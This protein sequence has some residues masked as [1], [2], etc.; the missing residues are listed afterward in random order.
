MLLLGWWRRPLHAGRYVLFTLLPAGAMVLALAVIAA[1]CFGLGPTLGG[2]VVGM[3]VGEAALLAAAAAFLPGLRRQGT[4]QLA[5]AETRLS[6][7]AGVGLGLGYL[8]AGGLRVAIVIAGLTLL[9]GLQQGG[10][11]ANQ[12][13][14]ASLGSVRL[15]PAGVALLFVLGVVV[16]PAAEEVYFR[17]GLLPW[18]GSRMGPHAALWVT[19]LIFGGL[20]AHYGISTALAVYY[21][22]VLGW[23]RLRTGSLLAPFLLHAVI[24]LVGG[25]ALLGG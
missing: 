23:A 20:H 7:S 5:S 14:Q 15:G 19:A 8:M 4:L 16:G 12:A 17:G 3:L 18:L 21:G 10:Q 2:S 9:L 6:A 1:G 11:E 13:L 22:Y 24:N 25:A